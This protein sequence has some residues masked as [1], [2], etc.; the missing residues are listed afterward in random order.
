MS[1]I[2]SSNQVLQK[3]K[4]KKN[5]STL[6]R[7]NQHSGVLFLRKLQNISEPFHKPEEEV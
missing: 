1:H 7:E 3:K 2:G 5:A 4:K 6:R